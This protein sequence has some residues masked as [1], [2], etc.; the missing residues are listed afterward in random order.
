[1]AGAV[2]AVQIR[3]IGALAHRDSRRFGVVSE[4]DGAADGHVLA[5]GLFELPDL[6]GVK[7]ALGRVLALDIE[8]SFVENTILSAACVMDA[9]IRDG[10]QIVPYAR[11]AEPRRHQG[12][13]I[14]PLVS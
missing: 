2:P 1:M 3:M 13:P 5:G 8:A 6:A 12:H 4:V 10:A 11:T 14:V 9:Q 7:R